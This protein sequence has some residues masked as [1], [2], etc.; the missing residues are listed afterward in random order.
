[1]TGLEKMI[2]QILEEA[3]C[4]ASA[5]VEEAK[6]QAAQMV[7][8]A[9]AEAEKIRE[10]LLGQSE[11]DAKNYLDRITSSADLQRR[12]AILRAKQ[13]V[14]A[15]V[16]QNAYTSLHEMEAEAYFAMIAKILEKYALPEA[17]ELYFSAADLERLPAGFEKEAE[18]IAAKK[19]GSL[20]LMK[21]SKEIEDG[22]VLVYGGVEEN[23]T[24]RALMGAKKDGLQDVIHQEL[25]A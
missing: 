7:E 10:E 15:S 6:A 24:F 18:A 20:T 11:V 8:E 17:G 1:M 19:G 21:E 12:T 3:D 25:F 13:D 4:A 5:K 14:I 16:L 22:C 23:C 9:K 2:G